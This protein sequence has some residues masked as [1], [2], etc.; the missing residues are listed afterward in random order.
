MIRKFLKLFLLLAALFLFHPARAGADTTVMLYMCGSNLETLNASATMDLLEIQSSGFD[1][2]EVH[3][4][5]L[6]GGS[7]SWASG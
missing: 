1:P 7:R 2:D 6:L 3:I 5:A 4:I